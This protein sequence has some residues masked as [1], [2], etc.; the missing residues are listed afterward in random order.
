[1]FGCSFFVFVLI[2]YVARVSCSSSIVILVKSLVS[3]T[4]ETLASYL[5]GSDLNTLCTTKDSLNYSPIPLMA[6]TT[7]STLSK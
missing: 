7:S 3:S 4:V 5:K 1:M 2:S 6:L